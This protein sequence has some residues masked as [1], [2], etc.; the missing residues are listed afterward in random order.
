MKKKVVAYGAAA[1][2]MAMGTGAAQAATVDW[3]GSGTILFG[4]ASSHSGLLPNWVG[5]NDKFTF[6]FEFNNPSPSTNVSGGGKQYPLTGHAIVTVQDSGNINN[7]FKY[8]FDT[9]SGG[10]DWMRLYNGFFTDTF[11]VQAKGTGTSAQSNITRA[12]ANFSITTGPW[13]LSGTGLPG[14][15]PNWGLLTLPLFTFTGAAS[16][17]PSE[18]FSGYVTNLQAASPVP[19]PAAAWL[20]VSGLAGVGAFA[21]R[22]RKIGDT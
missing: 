18:F 15:P 1:L 9:P 11:A 10:D 20:L 3:I 7:V 13:L 6:E 22:R 8:T 2:L 14:S 16:T 21:R 12:Q 5:S 17:G 19:L 4:N